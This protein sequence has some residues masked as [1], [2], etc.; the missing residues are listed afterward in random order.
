[1]TS[2]LSIAY[3]KKRYLHQ[4]VLEDLKEKMVFLG[5]PRQ[6]GKTTL[7]KQ[8]FPKDKYGYLN[9]DA[10]EDRERILSK[11]LP[12]KAL[13]IFDELHKYRRWRNYIKGLYDKRSKGQKILV[14]GSARLDYYRFGGDSLQGRYHYLRLYPLSLAEVKAPNALDD[15]LVL[16]GFPEPFFKGSDHKAKRWTLE[17]RRRLIRE[18]LIDLERVS[19][20]G[21]LELM[22]LRLPALVGSPLSIDNLRENLQIS[23]KTASHWLDIF[24]RLYAIFRVAPFGMDRIRAV[25][26]AQKL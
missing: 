12:S 5:G 22:M 16:G 23:H 8:L 18:D 21:Q 26:K 11:I 20:V 10:D 4:H 14:T 6:V 1:M 3:M 17:N 9:W 2:S 13:W 19:D 25:K 7:S 24:E 15:L